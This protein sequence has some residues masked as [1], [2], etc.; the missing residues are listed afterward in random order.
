[1]I[2]IILAGMYKFN[3]VQDDIY[4]KNEKGEVVQLKHKE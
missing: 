3:I 1:V 2:A 4:I